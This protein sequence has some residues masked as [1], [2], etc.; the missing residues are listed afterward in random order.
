MG[1]DS[2]EKA[3]HKKRKRIETFEKIIGD[4]DTQKTIVP[5]SKDENQR[6]SLSVNS[7]DGG[8]RDSSTERCQ[9]ADACDSVEKVNLTTEKKKIKKSKK[10]KV[11]HASDG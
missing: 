6:D 10:L 3:E 7:G 9:A 4:V 1:S 8:V 11:K 5:Q 2:W